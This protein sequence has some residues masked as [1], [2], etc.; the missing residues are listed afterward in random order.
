MVKHD[1]QPARSTD[2]ADALFGA[3]VYATYG[4][5]SASAEVIVDAEVVEDVPATA[6]V[7]S[8]APVAQSTGTDLVVRP[9]AG[10]VHRLRRAE[11][12]LAAPY[13]GAWKPNTTEAG[14]ASKAAVEA[15]YDAWPAKR[16]GEVVPRWFDT[17]RFG[18]TVKN[19]HAKG[20]PAELIVKSAIAMPVLLDLYERTWVDAYGERPQD[21]DMHTVVHAVFDL[22]TQGLSWS[23]MQEAVVRAAEEGH[24]FVGR[25][26][27]EV[28]TEHRRRA[29]RTGRP[30][31]G[32]VLQSAYE[33]ALARQAEID[34]QKGAAA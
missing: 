2:E 9:A 3:Q 20:R 18:R 7:T 30:T 34:R 12:Y 24:V 5:S 17:P 26:Y 16:G 29:P 19:F 22:L 1:E 8:V 10:G 21:N 25:T 28:L 33:K 6:T 15:L 31:Q 27:R 23:L 14:K 4:A 32:Q 11:E 13:S